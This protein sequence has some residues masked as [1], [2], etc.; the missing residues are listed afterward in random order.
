MRCSVTTKYLRESGRE[1]KIE[2]ERE[3]GRESEREKE[4]GGRE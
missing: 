4:G 1:R 2:R 3:R